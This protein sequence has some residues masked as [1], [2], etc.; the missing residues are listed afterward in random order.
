MFPALLMTIVNDTTI[1]L[2]RFSIPYLYPL[3]LREMARVRVLF[4]GPDKCN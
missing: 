4:S 2:M 1:A 3:S